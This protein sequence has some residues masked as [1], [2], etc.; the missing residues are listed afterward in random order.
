MARIT[1]RPLA[2]SAPSKLLLL[3][4][5]SVTALIDLMPDSGSA[6]SKPFVRKRKRLTAR[7]TWRPLAGRAPSKLFKEVT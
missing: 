2:G 6:P 1:W 4:V 7:I 3:I 5:N